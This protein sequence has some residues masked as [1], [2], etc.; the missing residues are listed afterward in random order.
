MSE[1]PTER[2]ILLVRHCESSHH[3]PEAPLTAA[4]AAAAEALSPSL[5]AFGADALYSSPFA[6]AT[7]TVAPFARGIGLAIV[8]DAR[9]RERGL[10]S[11]ERHDE[12]LA[13]VRASFDDAYFSAPQGESFGEVR[14]RALAAL[15]DIADR[16]HRAIVSGHGQWISAVLSG[17]DARFGFEDWRALTNPA[18]ILLRWQGGA[19]VGH[20]SCPS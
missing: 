10:P 2:H 18:L 5:A 13:H 16:H 4:G 6:R 19:P 9:L 17:I 8:T 1:D 7:A 14:T 3:A 15:R 12:F 11:F 20:A